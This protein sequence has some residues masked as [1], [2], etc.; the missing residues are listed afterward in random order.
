MCFFIYTLPE[1]LYLANTCETFVANMWMATNIA[2]D[3]SSKYLPSIKRS[4]I[5]Y[6]V[7]DISQTFHK[8]GPKY[9]SDICQ[10]FCMYV[11]NI[12]QL[13]VKI[14]MKYFTNYKKLYLL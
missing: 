13:L 9:W 8:H 2:E 7:K 14:F 6:I 10:T 11:L 5:L 1:I 4:S 12:I 3:T